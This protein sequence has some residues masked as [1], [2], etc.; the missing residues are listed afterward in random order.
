MSADAGKVVIG[1]YHHRH[2]IPPYDAPDAQLHFLIPRK[3][4]FLLR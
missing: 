3:R 4:R 2:G 1:P